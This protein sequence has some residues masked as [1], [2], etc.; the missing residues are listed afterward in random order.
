MIVIGKWDGLITN[1][2][3][4]SVPPS[5][6]VTQVNLQCLIPGELR[7]R[8]GLTSVSFATHTGTTSPVIRAVHYQNGT[9]PNIVY[10][11]ALGQLFVAK[12]PS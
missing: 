12:G 6:A 10:H 8:Q 1:A 11:N 7:T 4:Y 9:A 3:P 5:A 2:S